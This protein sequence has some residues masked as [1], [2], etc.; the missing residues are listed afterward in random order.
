MKI[1]NKKISK[2]KISTKSMFFQNQLVENTKFTLFARNAIAILEKQ[3]TI[4][5]PVVG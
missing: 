3:L 2:K 4:N 5:L 1:K